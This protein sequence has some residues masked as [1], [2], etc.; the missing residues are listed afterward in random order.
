LEY[1][2]YD[3]S[4]RPV[5]SGEYFAGARSFNEELEYTHYDLPGTDDLRASSPQ[6]HP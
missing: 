3:R 5:E 1:T 6:S 4:G 2:H